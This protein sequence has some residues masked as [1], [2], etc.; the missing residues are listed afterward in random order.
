MNQTVIWIIMFFAAFIYGI[1]C[2]CFWYRNNKKL[3]IDWYNVAM[4]CNDDWAKLCEKIEA[5]RDTLKAR[6]AELEAER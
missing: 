4:K 2:N 1:A 6:V 5:E 3:N